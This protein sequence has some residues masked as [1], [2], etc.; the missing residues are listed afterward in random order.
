MVYMFLVF[1]FQTIGLNRL[2]FFNC[3]MTQEKRMHNTTITS[4]R[5]DPTD[6]ELIE[7]IKQF[8][9]ITM[10]RDAMRYALRICVGGIKE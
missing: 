3:F 2:C 5:L 9:G 6:F 1:V 8:T 10:N 7:Q 4:V